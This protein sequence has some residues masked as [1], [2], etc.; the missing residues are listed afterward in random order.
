MLKTRAGAM[1]RGQSKAIMWED[2]STIKDQIL[3]FNLRDKVVPAVVGNG[4]QGNNE[5]NVYYRRNFINKRGY[6]VSCYG[7]ET[8]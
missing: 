4:R 5:W 8:F 2:A 1:A 3:E 6:E 7:G